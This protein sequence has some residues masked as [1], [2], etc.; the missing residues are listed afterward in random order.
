MHYV[1]AEGINKSY[2]IQPL[3]SDIS[4]N[5]EEGDKISLVAR[6]G[7][8]KTTLLK[9][10]ARGLGI[11][12]PITSPTFVVMKVYAVPGH[13]TI[14]QFVHV[15]CYRLPMAELTKIGL[16]DYLADPQ[17]VVAIEWASKLKLKR[18]NLLRLSLTL[19]KKSNERVITIN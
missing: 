13:K 18:K 5:I 17:T 9:G 2:G 12:K 15:D 3:F 11:K 6:N 10:L 7:S 1:S 4:F 14:T 19:G 8:G 16:G